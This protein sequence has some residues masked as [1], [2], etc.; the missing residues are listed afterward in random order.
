MEVSQEILNELL[1]SICKKVVSFG[2][3]LQTSNE[4]I[5]CGRCQPPK[6][7]YF[8]INL[9]EKLASAL[10]FPCKNKELGC[11]VSLKPEE[12][13]L[14]EE[15]CNNNKYGC[16]T[17]ILDSNCTWTGV[18]ANIEGHYKDKHLELITE[19]PLHEI[20]DIEHSY[21]KNLFFTYRGFS[22]LMKQR[23]DSSTGTLWYNVKLLDSALLTNLFRYTVTLTRGS[24]KLVRSKQVQLYDMHYNYLFDDNIK[25]IFPYLFEDLHDQQGIKFHLR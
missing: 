4:K 14:H 24:D 10:K 11:H 20:L 15:S 6:K 22:F 7:S 3:V 25:I 17:L 5:I 19:H 9:Y 21:V 16:P 12:L 18:L 8:R 23:C 1:C 13:K 2:P